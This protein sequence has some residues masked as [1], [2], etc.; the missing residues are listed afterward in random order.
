MPFP[1]SIRDL[2]Q[3]PEFWSQYFFETWGLEFPELE[4]CR[5]EFPVGLDH[6]LVLALDA[7][8][9]H[10]GLN[11]KHAGSAEPTQIAWDDESH[12]HPHVLRWEELDLVCRCVALADP[13]LPH[14]GL[15]LVLLH[16]FAPVCVDDRPE[17]IHPLIQEAYRTVGAFSEAQ[18]TEMV[19]RY[20]RRQDRFVWRRSEPH[21]WFPYQDDEEGKRASLYSI[22][23]PDNAV[24]PFDGL[25]AMFSAAQKRLTAAV[26][27]KWLA[28][29]AGPIARSV[30]I[31]GDVS[32]LPV[33]ADALQEAGCDD[34]VI[35]G[36]LR[37]TG[38]PARGCWVVETL[39]GLA[40]GEL[41]ARAL[42][43]TRR[44]D[45]VVYR[46]DMEIP[47][48]DADG[49]FNREY[50]SITESLNEALQSAGLGSA[51][52]YGAQSRAGA[53]LGE[54]DSISVSA[55]VN[56]DRDRGLAMIREV[57]TR[58]NVSR[59]IVIRLTAPAV[60]RFPLV[61]GG[62]V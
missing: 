18:V 27:P 17:V 56:D 41:I 43:H 31:S 5:L 57:L 45:R 50:R 28:G 20:D 8:L 55:R 15:P 44:P 61:P 3:R 29:D 19:H 2:A 62:P 26:D 36:S 33:L 39:L 46:F 22:R 14:P 21:G 52:M 54:Y 32:G 11:L 9:Y 6:A 51:Q 47:T 38:S 13:A 60:A 53:P 34:G 49:R 7:G 48:R 4:G 12:W 25:N 42:G 59:D 10:F 1:Q 16:R 40:P 37:A 24:F 58:A 23:N 35:L 30:A